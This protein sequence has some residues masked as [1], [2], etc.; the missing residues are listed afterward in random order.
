MD[1]QLS[2]YRKKQCE[3]FEKHRSKKLRKD[4]GTEQF[5]GD[6][7]EHEPDKEA[8]SVDG[9]ESPRRRKKRLHA[10]ETSTLSRTADGG[11]REQDGKTCASGISDIGVESAR[12]HRFRM[13]SW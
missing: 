11:R 8:D 13:L 2:E 5:T 9:S 12:Q 4:S 7:G 1:N 3:K 6:P 10:G